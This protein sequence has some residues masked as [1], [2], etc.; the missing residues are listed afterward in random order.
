MTD[1]ALKYNLLDNS[2]RKEVLD[3]I[4]FLLTKEKKSMKHGRNDYK[5]KILKV[6]VWSDSDIDLMIQNQ[7]K[8]GHI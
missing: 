8:F 6:S 4:D 1:L 5:K 3:F 2:A 7:Q